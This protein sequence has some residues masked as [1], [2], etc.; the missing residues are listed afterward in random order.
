V[1]SVGPPS[2]W[3]RE[4][5]LAPFPRVCERAVRGVEVLVVGAGLAGLAVA[6]AFAAR[7]AS[8]C[9][10]D[11]FGPG[12]GASGRNAGFVLACHPWD[13]PALRA[14]L[15]PAGAR[16]YLALSARSHRILVER[17]AD[18][19]DYRPCGSLALPV[20]GDEAEAERLEQAARL[21]AADGLACT[22]TDPPAGALA[23]FGR[24]LTIAGDAAVHPGKLV[25]RLA[26]GIT[27]VRGTVRRIDP[28]RRIALLDDRRISFERAFVCAGGY[29]A[30]I[31]G[32]PHLRVA[33]KRAQVLA[34]GPVPP[35]LGPVCYAGWGFD[36]FRQ[37][38]D[39]IVLAGGRRHL[40]EAAENTDAPGPTVPVQL[41]L[42]QYV[43]RHLPFAAEAPIVARWAGT[44]AFSADDVPILAPV[45]G[46][47]SP[48]WVL[49]G[50][51]GHGLGLAFAYAEAAADGPQDPLTAHRSP[52]RP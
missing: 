11:A 10:A 50:F 26:E 37:R 32:A 38:P 18:G 22:W 6:R 43:R 29:A 1:P 46:D 30:R 23:G 34:M 36:Y 33:P 9:V 45:P 7:G 5:A 35:A 42:E 3:Q 4:A 47:G 39:G 44:M 2:S 20:A 49:G 12:A 51:T 13:Y 17:Y 8:V 19:C 21:L 14:R 24:A 52:R 48:V 27:G 16:A 31:L 40:H 41:D 25:R 15:G 28:E